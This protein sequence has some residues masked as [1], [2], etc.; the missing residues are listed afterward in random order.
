MIR[1]PRG[2]AAAGAGDA[3]QKDCIEIKAGALPE[4]PQVLIDILSREKAS[5]EYW[6]EISVSNLSLC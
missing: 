1:V 2:G 5:I 3:S 6:L 4:D